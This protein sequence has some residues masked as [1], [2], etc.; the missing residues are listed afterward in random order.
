MKQITA[1]TLQ[2]KPLAPPKLKPVTDSA[3][4]SAARATEA[5][6]L[7]LKVLKVESQHGQSEPRN[8]PRIP[9]RSLDTVPR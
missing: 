5:A 3:F 7:P 9:E 2:L 8:Q 4:N 6:E 1:L